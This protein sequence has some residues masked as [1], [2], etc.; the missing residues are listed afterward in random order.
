MPLSVRSRPASSDVVRSTLQRGST[1]EMIYSLPRIINYIS[2]FTP[3]EP[4]DVIS[5]G[6]PGGIRPRRQNGQFLVPGDVV[7]MEIEDLGVMRH[8]VADEE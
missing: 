4:G 2:S 7:D 8:T 3:L 5:T 6:S 1:A